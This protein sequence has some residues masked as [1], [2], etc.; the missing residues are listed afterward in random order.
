MNELIA[1]TLAIATGGVAGYAIRAVHAKVNYE[2]W[3]K[4]ALDS[5][6][7]L[8]DYLT[9]K[10][11]PLKDFEFYKPEYL[12]SL[13]SKY[14]GEGFDAHVPDPDSFK[15]ETL[16]KWN[17]SSPSEAFEMNTPDPHHT[18][19]QP[20]L[21]EHKKSAMQHT[22]F[23]MKEF[24]HGDIGMKHD[25]KTCMG[26]GY[27]FGQE[28]IGTIPFE[29]GDGE[30]I[31]GPVMSTYNVQLPCPEC[32]PVSAKKVP[33]SLDEEYYKEKAKQNVMSREE[34]QAKYRAQGLD[35]IAD[36]LEP[37]KHLPTECG[38]DCLRNCAEDN[39]GICLNSQDRTW[40]TDEDLK[41]KMK[42][43]V[44]KEAK[45]GYN[46]FYKS[47]CH[48]ADVKVSTASESTQYHKCTKCNEACDIV[49]KNKNE[50]K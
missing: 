34:L 31:N 46:D 26:Q 38:M 7:M 6:K 25:C 32:Q 37:K 28:Q 41:G 15:K 12:E 14:G 17:K 44:S 5:E 11:H 33:S 18:S 39:D 9:K 36:A 24:K 45:M 10:D 43:Y 29:G 42:N 49:L 21:G 22:N 3:K 1:I 16:D 19:E 30:E 35:H 4:R 50:D 2:G 48:G 40:Y 20:F 23:R 13:F 47:D 8:V 27:V